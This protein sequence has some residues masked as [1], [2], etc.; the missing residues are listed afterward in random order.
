[1]HKVVL[2][3]YFSISKDW[4]AI[5]GHSQMSE[6][7]RVF[8]LVSSS[9]VFSAL[10][11]ADSKFSERDCGSW[12]FL[13]TPLAIQG[14]CVCGECV[15]CGVWCVCARV[16]VFVSVW[17]REREIEKERSGEAESQKK[18]EA[19]KQWGPRDHAAYCIPYSR[20]TAWNTLTHVVSLWTTLSRRVAERWV[21]VRGLCYICHWPLSTSVELS[22]PWWPIILLLIQ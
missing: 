21:T 7:F 8:L 13:G 11:S 1:M 6:F 18:N 20:N 4:W 9:V 14:V 17:I 3:G 12:E 19:Q 15:V 22:T 5:C 10:T 16:H 2:R